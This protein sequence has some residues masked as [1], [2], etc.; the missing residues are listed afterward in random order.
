MFFQ[1]FGKTRKHCNF[2]DHTRPLH[3]NKQYSVSV[4]SLWAGAII[5]DGGCKSWDPR[6]PM[7][8]D[9]FAV[10][11]EQII[12]ARIHAHVVGS[13]ADVFMFRDQMT[14]VERFTCRFFTAM[15]GNE[16]G[17]KN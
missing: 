4:E 9:N 11:S 12:P 14:R 3:T 16:A 5:G 2:V 17:N 1:N 13:R 8:L 7:I 6:A 15:A 10:F